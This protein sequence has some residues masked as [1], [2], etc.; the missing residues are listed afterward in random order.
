MTLAV[1]NLAMTNLD[2]TTIAVMNNA[3]KNLAE[4]HLVKITHLARN[5]NLDR[6]SQKHLTQAAQS[7]YLRQVSPLV[8]PLKHG[9][10]Q[11]AKS[12]RH[13]KPTLS[14]LMRDPSQ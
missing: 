13:I 8:S 10:T 5:I 4:N 11:R 1:R 6:T 2:V 3:M 7:F 14:R 12:R 9:G